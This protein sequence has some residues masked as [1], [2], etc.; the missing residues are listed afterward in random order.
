MD[1]CFNSTSR[2]K[3]NLYLK[4]ETVAGGE[5][6]GREMIDALAFK[7]RLINQR[8][9]NFSEPLIIIRFSYFD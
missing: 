4:G 3:I 6:M 8:L 5:G 1:A 2:K 9:F 7:T